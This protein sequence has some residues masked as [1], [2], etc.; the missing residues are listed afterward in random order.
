MSSLIFIKCAVLTCLCCSYPRIYVHDAEIKLIV[1][2]IIII[3]IMLS[4][5][6]QTVFNV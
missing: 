4:S 3:I 2:I 5:L 6:S 1:I